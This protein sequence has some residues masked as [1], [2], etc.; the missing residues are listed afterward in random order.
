MN[1]LLI[2]FCICAGISFVESKFQ[3]Y[4]IDQSND[5]ECKACMFFANVTQN[6]IIGENITIGV[7]E[8]IVEDLCQLI[9]GTI[10]YNECISVIN[11]FQYMFDMLTNGF[12]PLS[13]CEKL[14][15]CP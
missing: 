7:I 2:L 1:N 4:I 9:G 15:M 10:I 8:N 6:M 5:T 3:I 12:S 13:I 11:I 14:K